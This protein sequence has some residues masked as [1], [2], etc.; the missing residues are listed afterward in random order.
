[1]ARTVKDPEVR[2]R[3]ILDGALALFCE[4]G[5]EAVTMGEIAG[6]LG[7]AQGLCYR[8][9]PSKEA[10]L[11]EAVE[12]YARAL[13]GRVLPLFRNDGRSLREKLGEAPLFLEEEEEDSFYWRL[14]HS[15]GS[16]RVHA[17]LSLRVCSLLREAA[18][19]FC[20]EAMDCGGL[21]AEEAET[22]WDFLIYGQLGVLLRA[23]LSREEKE[24]RIRG[25]YARIP[26]QSG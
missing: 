15:G 1:M 7:I 5:Y 10:L 17:Q 16:E 24:R 9:F 23:D 4:K 26:F 11:D 6:R 2:R 8:Y 20:A 12:Q 3:E 21:N 19:G 22:A 13:A 18:A 14:A 25:F